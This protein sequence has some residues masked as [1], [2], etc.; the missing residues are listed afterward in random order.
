MGGTDQA[1]PWQED[2]EAPGRDTGGAYEPTEEEEI[3]N[4]P[5]ATPADDVQES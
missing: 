1:Q 4:V 5:G 2:D 3:P